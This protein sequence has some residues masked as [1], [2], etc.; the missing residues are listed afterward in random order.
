MKTI[1]TLEIY[2][3]AFNTLLEKLQREEKHNADFKMEHGR[4]CNI[5]TA[6]IEKYTSQINELHEE[7]LK[8]EK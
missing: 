2:K 7:I 1:T 6:R 3:M 4:E 5:A 8:L